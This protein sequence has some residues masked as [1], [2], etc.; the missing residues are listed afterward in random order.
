MKVNVKHLW[1]KTTPVTELL[2][3]LHDS[4]DFTFLSFGIM[5]TIV[6]L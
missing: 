4:V 3:P 2:P 1:L 6:E 5:D